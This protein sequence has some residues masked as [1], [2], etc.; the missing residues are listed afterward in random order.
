[1]DWLWA[2]D[3]L[4]KKTRGLG[5]LNGH[6][7]W[8]AAPLFSAPD[9]V[10]RLVDSPSVSTGAGSSFHGTASL[11]LIQAP[12]AYER[13]ARRDQARATVLLRP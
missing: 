11:P 13:F 7:G 5:V 4:P 12:R 6:H 1:M 10:R 3:V 9:A 2:H 8:A